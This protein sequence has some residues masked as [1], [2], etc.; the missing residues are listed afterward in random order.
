MLY[1]DSLISA[2]KLAESLL[3]KIDQPVTLSDKLEPAD[4]PKL[5]ISSESLEQLC[6]ALHSISPSGSGLY[7]ELLSLVQSNVL[8]VRSGIPVLAQDWWTKVDIIILDDMDVSWSTAADPEGRYCINDELRDTL[9]EKWVKSE[10]GWAM[11]D[12]RKE[13]I[14]EFAVLDEWREA[15][16]GRLEQKANHVEG[17][18]RFGL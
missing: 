13:L 8:E 4:D 14:F 10:F 2:A 3:G 1:Q 5:D 7:D 11:V 16:E 9:E 18:G 6:L 15:F 12:D 17:I